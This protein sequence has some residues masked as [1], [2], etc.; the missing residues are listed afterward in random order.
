MISDREKNITARS[1][2]KIVQ[3]KR[4]SY[5]HLRLKYKR[6]DVKK[7]DRWAPKKIKMR[8]LFEIGF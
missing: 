6:K 4:K 1:Q 2:S 3:G 7:L 8:K 5:R